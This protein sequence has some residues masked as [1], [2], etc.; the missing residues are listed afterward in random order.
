MQKSEAVVL[1]HAYN[2][3]PHLHMCTLVYKKL[4]F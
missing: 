2:A 1:V 4:G 3:D